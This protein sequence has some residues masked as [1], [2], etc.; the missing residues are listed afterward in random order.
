MFCL[1]LCMAIWYIKIWNNKSWFLFILLEI[2]LEEVLNFWQIFDP[3]EKC[4]NCSKNPDISLEISDNAE[5][6]YGSSG[7]TFLFCDSFIAMTTMAM[8]I[9]MRT[10]T[11]A[12][13]PATTATPRPDKV[14]ITRTHGWY[15]YYR[16]VG[17][18]LKKEL[19]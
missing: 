2:F 17:V 4:W 14:Q 18:S 11:P 5:T 10:I 13:I 7:A 16:S 1:W 15:W 19:K 9:A 3:D 6:F 12:M 8:R